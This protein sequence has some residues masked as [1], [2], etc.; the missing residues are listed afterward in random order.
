MVVGLSPGDQT[1]FPRRAPWWGNGVG[2]RARV[3]EDGVR[4]RAPGGAVP[5]EDGRGGWRVSRDAVSERGPHLGRRP[6]SGAARGEVRGDGGLDASG[7]AVGRGGRAASRP[8]GR[9]PWGGLALPGDVGR[10]AVDRLDM[11]APSVRVDVRRGREADAAGDRGGR[12]VRM[13]PNR[14]SVTMTSN[15]DGFVVRK[16]VAASTCR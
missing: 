2:S 6:Y 15:R 1:S 10:G 14:L 7:L 9:S 12:S 11:A 4:R 3:C 16:M 8:R 5:G 13:S